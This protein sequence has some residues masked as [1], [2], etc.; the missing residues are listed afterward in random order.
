[1][2]FVRVKLKTGEYE[3]L[4]TNLLDEVQFPTEDFLDIYHM[5]WGVEGF[6][7]MQENPFK[8]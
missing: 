7:A 8:P 2:R 4:V 5:R 1:V 6:Y 3:V